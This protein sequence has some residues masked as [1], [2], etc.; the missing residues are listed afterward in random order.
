[1]D[2]MSYC[3]AL[4]GA[5]LR[6]CPLVFLSQG[7]YS[8]LQKLR[9]GMKKGFFKVPTAVGCMKKGFFEVPIAVGSMKKGFLRLQKH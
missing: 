5:V 8:V 9:D 6:G 4:Q 2:S 7:G 3:F 1:M